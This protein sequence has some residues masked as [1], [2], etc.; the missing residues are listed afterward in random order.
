GPL[1]LPPSATSPSA[2][3]AADSETEAASRPSVFNPNYRGEAPLAPKGS[4]R[5]FVLDPLPGPDH[6]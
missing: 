2:A 4:K 5:S 6:Q 3:A 1:D